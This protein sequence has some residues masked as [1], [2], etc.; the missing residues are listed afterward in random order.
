MTALTPTRLRRYDKAAPKK[1]G[2]STLQ[3]LT[4]VVLDDRRSA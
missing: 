1:A 4:V 3:P 2:E